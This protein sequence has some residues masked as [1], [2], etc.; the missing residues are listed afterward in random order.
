ML[1]FQYQ[2]ATI[3]FSSDFLNTQVADLYFQKLFSSIPWKEN[4]V[5]LFGKRYK[6]PRLESFHAIEEKSYTYSGNKLIAHA[7]T[8]ELLELKDQ[9]EAVTDAKFNCV[10]VNL[11]RNGN[12]SNGWHA[13]NEKELGKNPSIASL[14][15]GITRR[16]D[17]KHIENQE[18]ISFDLNHGSLL[19]M[20][21]ETQHFW[22]HQI[23][24]SK[25]IHEPRI[26]LTFRWIH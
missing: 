8:K 24:K 14:S 25:K 26:N 1:S 3:K 20:E 2:N 21:G 16:F 10:L 4:E 9:I 17:L 5:I 19:L 22:K 11:Y 18:K 15:L 7:F 12:D 13:D 6:T 23:A